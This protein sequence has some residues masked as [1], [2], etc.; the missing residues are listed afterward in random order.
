MAK[1]L[2]SN[3][4]PHG[5]SYTLTDNGGGWYSIDATYTCCQIVLVSGMTLIGN[6]NI[7]LDFRAIEPVHE[8]IPKGLI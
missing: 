1:I 5:H 6:N 4:C 3:E 8:P 2:T 7:T